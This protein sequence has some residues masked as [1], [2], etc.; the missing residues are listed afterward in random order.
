VADHVARLALAAA[1]NAGMV[2]DSS[3]D[4]GHYLTLT[5]QDR[6]AVQPVILL[7]DGRAVVWSQIRRTGIDP[8]RAIRHWCR[9]MRAVALLRHGAPVAPLVVRYEDICRDPRAALTRLLA[10]AGLPFGEPAVPDL[11]AIGGSPDFQPS[12][13]DELRV[14]E[15]WREDMPVALQARFER[16]A[17]RLNRRL[18]AAA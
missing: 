5:L 8:G 13:L 4:P 11:H 16:A 15:R 2:V 1:G 17:G 14:D 10:T 9:V 7:R 6:I 12:Q 18:G 3:K